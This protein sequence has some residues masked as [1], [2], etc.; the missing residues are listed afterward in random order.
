MIRKQTWLLVGIFALLLGLAFYLRQNPLVNSAS[1][2]PT[3][4]DPVVM[5]A[6]WQ[7][8][9]ITWIEYKNSQE[10]V[11]ELTRNELGAWVLGAE[12]P[13]TAEAGKAE[14][15]RSQ[16]ANIRVMS[17]MDPGYDLE[18]LGLKTPER[19]LSIRDAQGRKVEMHFGR[20][21]PTGTGYY[22]QVD[23]QAP[24]IVSKY[25]ADAIFDLLKKELL[26]PVPPA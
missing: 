13:Q 15:I 21:T 11:I 6:G 23:G 16:I 19:I 8:G 3:P 17:Y 12:D 7:S 26:V 25:G 5:L 22:V 24:H 2:T 20:L 14:Q 1:I 9:D 4:T 10:S 18:A